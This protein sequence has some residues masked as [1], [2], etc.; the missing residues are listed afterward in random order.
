MPRAVGQS[1]ALGRE[2]VRAHDL[3]AAGRDVVERPQRHVVVDVRLAD[4]RLAVG[5]HEPDVAD[6]LGEV[7]AVVL[8]EELAVAGVAAGVVDV[9]AP[10]HLRAVEARAAVDDAVQRLL[11][12]EAAHHAAPAQRRGVLEEA[13]QQQRLLA[14]VLERVEALPLWFLPSLCPLC[15]CG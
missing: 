14:R 11:V 10:A 5:L 2:D 6:H 12:A 13:L 4:E 8:V 1:H 15:L 9:V 7:P 3:A